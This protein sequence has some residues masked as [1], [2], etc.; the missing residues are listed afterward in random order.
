MK[1]ANLK[2]AIVI[3]GR[4]TSISLEDDFWDGLKEVA[5]SRSLTTHQLV[6]MIKKQRRRGTLSCA[7]RLCVIDYY[8]KRAA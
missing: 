8:Y 2:R 5:K 7:I 4:K 3:D 6:S 1:S